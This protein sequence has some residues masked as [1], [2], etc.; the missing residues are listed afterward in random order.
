MIENGTPD[1][2]ARNNIWPRQPSVLPMVLNPLKKN[3]CK[4]NGT[5]QSRSGIVYDFTSLSMP[6]DCNNKRRVARLSWS[7]HG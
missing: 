4:T 5:V 6:V 2:T 7:I 3:D 1:V